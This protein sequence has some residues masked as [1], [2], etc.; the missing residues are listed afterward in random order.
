[1]SEM[2]GQVVAAGSVEPRVESGTAQARGTIDATCGCKQLEQRVLDF[3]PG[4]SDER[5]NPEFDRQIY[6]ARNVVK[7][8]VGRLKESA[9]SRPYDAAADA[10]PGRGDAG[11]AP[12][13]AAKNSRIEPPAE[14]SEP[15]AGWSGSRG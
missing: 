8:P 9:R 12:K 3:L 5:E 14:I 4:R 11:L 10:L 6:R 13:R 15:V 1:M 2:T 7:R